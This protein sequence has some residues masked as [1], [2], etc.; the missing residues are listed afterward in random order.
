[1][2]QLPSVS[3]DAMSPVCKKP[4]LSMV[5]AVAA[6]FLWY[7]WR[8]PGANA[9]RAQQVTGSGALAGEGGGP[10][11]GGDG[12]G[13]NTSRVKTPVEEC[14]CYWRCTHM[15]RKE[16]GGGEGE[17]AQSRASDLPYPLMIWGPRIHSSPSF[18]GSPGTLGP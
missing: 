3:N 16:G 13:T 17:G 14:R 10:G 7:L 9:R 18:S 15:S 11:G 6:G 2:K 5:S 12:W 4:S 8:P 1:M